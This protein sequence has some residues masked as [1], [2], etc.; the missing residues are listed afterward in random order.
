MKNE[1]HLGH[2][3][4]RKRQIGILLERFIDFFYG[5]E[6]KMSIF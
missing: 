4:D 5:S 2:I 6:G 1:Y 3:Q